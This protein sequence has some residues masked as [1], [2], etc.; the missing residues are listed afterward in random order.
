MSEQPPNPPKQPRLIPNA[1]YYPPPPGQPPYGGGFPP[2][3]GGNP[4]GVPPQPPKKKRHIVRNVFIGLGAFILILIIAGVAGGKNSTGS[5][6]SGNVS[7]PAAGETASSPAA[8]AAEQPSAAPSP[9]PSASFAA[10]TLLTVSGSGQYT[11]QKYTVGGSG[12]YDIYWTYGEGAMGSRVNF[13]ISGDGG[14]DFNVNNPNQL[15]TGGSGVVH[16]YSDSGA[17]YLEIGSEG[18]WASRWSQ[19]RS[20]PASTRP[21]VTGGLVRVERLRRGRSG[22][23][24]IR[25]ATRRWGR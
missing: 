16:V 20:G 2:G 19:H 4:Y 23:G 10:Q 8:A 24:T 25:K 21:T 14:S 17:H 18:N 12:D 6:S 9:S 22:S 7:S 11:T 3:P 1:A 13:T 5:S 15:G